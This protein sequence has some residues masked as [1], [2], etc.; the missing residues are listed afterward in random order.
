MKI[1]LQSTGRAENNECKINIII[2]NTGSMGKKSLIQVKPSNQ[3]LELY[4]L[5][6]AIDQDTIANLWKYPFSK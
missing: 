1:L 6:A 2:T 3:K 5:Y 4:A